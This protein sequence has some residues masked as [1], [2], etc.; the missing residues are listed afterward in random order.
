MTTVEITKYRKNTRSTIPLGNITKLVFAII[1]ASTTAI[2][3]YYICSI[4]YMY[5]NGPS[6]IIQRDSLFILQPNSLYL[7]LSFSRLLYRVI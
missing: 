2:D 5:K 1:S 3:I 6:L 7:F 4:V